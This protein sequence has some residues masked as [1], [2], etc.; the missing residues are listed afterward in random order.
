MSATPLL[1]IIFMIAAAVVGFV[2]GFIVPVII[3]GAQSLVG[4]ELFNLGSLTSSPLYPILGGVG[5]GSITLVFL[6]LFGNLLP[7]RRR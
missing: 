2:F 1:V 3:A 5:L 4:V 6:A 7:L